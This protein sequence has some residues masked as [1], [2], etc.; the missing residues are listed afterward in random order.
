MNLSL[1]SGFEDFLETTPAV[2]DQSLQVMPAVSPEDSS[3]WPDR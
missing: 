1:F 3:P 2:L